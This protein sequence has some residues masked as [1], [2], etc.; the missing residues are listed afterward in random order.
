MIV[1][2]RRRTWRVENVAGGVM[3]AAPIDDLGSPSQ[4]FLLELE[5]PEPG[6]LP[7]PSLQTLGDPA[8][9]HLFLQAVRLD[10]L[11]GTAPFV[12]IQ[13]TAVIPVE[14]QLVPLVMA[15]RQPV[16]RLLLADTTGLGKTVEA[17]LLA[18]ELLARGRARSV[19]IITPA[20]LREQWRQQMRDLFYLDFEIMSGETRKRLERAIPPG[21]DPWLYFDRLI[22]SIDYAK[23]I[24]VRPEI[25]KRRWDLVIVDE[26]HNA[27]MPHGQRARRADMERWEAV[28]QIAATCEHLLLLTATPHSGY[29]DSYC[30]LL[31]MLA[32]T[33]VSEVNGEPRPVREEASHHVCQRTRKDVQK[34]FAEAGQKFPFPEREDPKDTEVPVD[35]HRDYLRIIGTMDAVL[36]LVRTHAIGAG[37]EQPFEWLRLHLHRRALSSPEALRC[38]LQNRL[39]RL[40]EIDAKEV[41][42]KTATSNATEAPEPVEADYEGPLLASLADQGAADVETESDRDNKADSALL[43]V[44]QRL[45]QKHFREL[46]EALKAI[47]P[48]RDRKLEALRDT[49]IPTLLSKAAIHTPARVIVFTRFKD[50]LFYLERELKR[51][52]D[53]EVISLYGDLSE[54]ERDR[55]F[56]QFA[57]SNRAVLLATDVISEGLNLQVAA[58]MVVHFDLPWNPNRIDQRNGRI[59]R[60]GQRAPMVFIRTLYCRDTTD[61]DVM[62]VLVRKLEAMRRDLGFSPPFFAA[63]ETVLHVLSRRRSRRRAIAEPSLFD[64]DGQESMADELFDRD[65]VGRIT[66]EGFYGQADVRISDVSE[67]LREAHRRVGSPEQIRRFIRDGL[68]HYQ[69][70]VEARRDGTLRVEIANPRL[71]VPGVPTELP[72]VVLDP[73]EKALHPDAEV[74]DVGHPLMRRLNAAL[75]EDALRQTSEGARTAAWHV[76]GQRGTFLIGHG[77]LRATAD[78]RP[79][80]LLEEVVIFGLRAGLDGY[81]VLS[82]DEAEAAYRQTPS[83]RQAVR[84]DALRD[85]RK[86]YQQPQ[87]AEAQSRAVADAMTTL[88]RHREAM[89]A[90]LEASGS[91]SSSWLHGFDAVEEIGFDLYCLTLLLP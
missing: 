7:E 37:K 29:T 19:L 82:R 57:S 26:A 89:K 79:P 6:T 39:D 3:T 17:G 42:K 14:Y 9:Q 2:L 60:F 45:Q 47:K 27:A 61:E 54:A 5:K 23:D 28:D 83:A 75:R 88:K 16:A 8:L 62:D 84:D 40:K 30:S 49:V 77:L 52:T 32:P 36:E 81:S 66:S 90:E 80:T 24:R 72:K 13:R 78:T 74:L 18:T 63:E 10:A 70:G 33:L 11:H 69:C 22:V 35:L 91:G 50:T 15:L 86:L 44:D 38:S 53:Y 58:C 67:R 59:D 43:S 68:T 46:L 64:L 65:A 76:E 31:K 55:R 85:L 41:A 1:N 48:T 20:N 25:R 56:D 34:W 4:Q 21:A 51:Q 73:E 12:A 87:W 71:R